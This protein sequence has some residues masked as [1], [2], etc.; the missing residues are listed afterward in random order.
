M[1][2]LPQEMKEPSVCPVHRR[3]Y[4]YTVTSSGVKAVPG[5]PF[6]I[7]LGSSGMIVLAK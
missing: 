5:S 6:L 4:V 7:P 2:C 1:G 3:V